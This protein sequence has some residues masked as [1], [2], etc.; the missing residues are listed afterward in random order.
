MLHKK[1]SACPIFRWQIINTPNYTC[2]LHVCLFIAYYTEFIRIL[3][4]ATINFNLAGVW[5]LIEGGF[6]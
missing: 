2:I 4:V 3:A 1:C 5:L 6:Y